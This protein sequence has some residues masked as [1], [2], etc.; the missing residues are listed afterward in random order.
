MKK[1]LVFISF[2]GISVGATAQLVPLQQQVQNN[3]NGLILQS[4]SSVFTGF[5]SMNWQEWNA[6]GVLQKSKLS[7]SIFGMSLSP[8]GTKRLLN[9]NWLQWSGKNYAVTANPI[10]EGTIGKSND[11]DG[12][13]FNGGI[14]ANIQGVFFDNKL[15]FGFEGY[16]AVNEFPQYIDEYIAQ[17]DNAVPG[18]KRVHADSKGRY[19]YTHIDGYLSYMPSEHISIT[20]GYGK[21]F[22][23]DG[24]RSLL[25]SDNADSYPYLRLKAA[26]WRL[27]YNVVYSRLNNPDQLSNGAD[28]GKYSVFHYL[29]ANVGKH[30]QL[31]FFENLIW[32]AK[33]SNYHRG[34]DVQYLNPLP[35]LWPLNFSLGSGDNEFMGFTGKYNLKS[36]Y[37]YGQF[38]FDDLNLGQTFKHKKQHINNKYFFQIGTWQ[39]NIFHV[40]GLD[41]RLEWNGVRPYTYGHRDPVGQN[42]T[43][44]HQPIAD[45][46]GANFHEFVSI[47]NYTKGRWYG[48]LQ[49]MFTLRGENPGL[50]Y[51]NGEDLWGGEAGVPTLGSQTLQGVV[52]RYF[53]NQLSLGYLINPRN[54]LSIEGNVGYFVHSAK[55]FSKNSEFNFSIGI[56][57]NLFNHYYDVAKTHQVMF[58]YAN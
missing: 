16:R 20:T 15:S 52:H 57:T 11:K 55:D 43:T 29:G 12:S 6:S 58:N 17:N 10:L 24:Y 48:V 36:G 51:N 3:L 41:W 27:T 5:R 38:G 30:L 21:L 1:I 33:D 56:K 40:E 32:L 54:R 45:P 46:F 50:T 35:V 37:I 2:F 18:E 25:W 13:L 23:G 9:S 44:N 47:F 26:Y 14:G 53:I 49:D 7:D 34:F 28:Q 8:V 39:H 22:V 4:G 19:N 42:Y 31:G